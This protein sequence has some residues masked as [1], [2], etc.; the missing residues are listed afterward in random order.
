MAT[1]HVRRFR[2][3]PP[4]HPQRTKYRTPSNT[5]RI[6]RNRALEVIKNEQAI[7]AREEH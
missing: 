5:T 4:L 6:Q 7:A 1:Q 2:K 3:E